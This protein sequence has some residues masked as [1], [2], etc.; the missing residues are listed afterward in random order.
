[1]AIVCLWVGSRWC[2]TRCE[3]TGSDPG[4]C[5]INIGLPSIGLFRHETLFASVFAQAHVSCNRSHSSQCSG[6]ELVPLGLRRGIG[7]L[8]VCS[9]EDLDRV[10]SHGQSADTRSQQPAGEGAL[11]IDDL[12]GDDIVIRDDH[13]DRPVSHWKDARHHHDGL[14][15]AVAIDVGDHWT[16]RIAIA[17]QH[18]HAAAAVFVDAAHQGCGADIAGGGERNHHG[19]GSES[20]NGHRPGVDRGWGRIG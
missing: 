20:F 9:H 17:K 16:G 18:A 7:D 2:F 19:A 12:M 3:T 4:L 15:N 14:G 8:K 5:Q 6:G 13:D 10:A 11:E 1:M